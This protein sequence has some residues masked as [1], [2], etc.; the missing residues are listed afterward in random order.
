[1]TPDEVI[2]LA[3]EANR[4]AMVKTADVLE[5][6]GMESAAVLARSADSSPGEYL[7]MNQ[8]L[9]AAGVVRWWAGAPPPGEDGGAA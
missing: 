7:R 2:K 1:M 5:N 8:A 6:I 3:I 4:A 9:A